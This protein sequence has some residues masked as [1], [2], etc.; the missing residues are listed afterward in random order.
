VTHWG[1]TKRGISKA[2][3]FIAA[4]G[5]FSLN[6]LVASATSI[7][8]TVTTATI[9]SSGNASV[10]SSETGT[11]YLVNE[12]L[13]ITNVASITGAADDLWNSVSISTANTNTNLAATGLRS[14]TYKVY[15][16]DAAGNLSAASTNTISIKPA[17]PAAPDLDAGSDLG[18]SPTDNNT[19]DD[20]PTFNVSSLES[21]TVV[22]LTATPSVGNPVTCSFTATGTSGTCTFDS[23]PNGTYSIRAVQSGGGVNSDASTA[24]GSVVINKQSSI[25]ANPDLD[26][27]SDFGLSKTDNITNDDTPK[28]NVSGTFFGTARVTASRAGATNVTCTISSNTCTLGSL[29][30]GVWSIAV[31]DSDS[32]G[33]SSTSAESLT[34]TIDTVRPVHSFV[35][36]RVSGGRMVVVLQSTEPGT[37]FLYWGGDPYFLRASTDTLADIRADTRDDWWNEALIASA[38]TPVEMSTVSLSRTG[39]YYTQSVMDIAGNLSVRGSPL[40]APGELSAPSATSTSAPTGT[41]TFGQILTNA[42]TYSGV[43][44]PSRTFQWKRCTSSSDT[45]TCTNISGAT[46]STYT[47]SI[48][49]VGKFLR[50]EVTASNGVGSNSTNLSSATSAILAAPYAVTDVNASSTV[51]GIQKYASV[52]LSW[53]FGADNG[54]TTANHQWSIDGTNWNNFAEGS[55][56]GT[57]GTISQSSQL[58]FGTPY[59]FRIR[60]VNSSSTSSATA[61]AAT[62]ISLLPGACNPTIS[63]DGKTYIFTTVGVCEWVIPDQIKANAATFDIRG[64]QGGGSVSLKGTNLAGGRRGGGLG[65]RIRGTINLAALNSLFVFVGSKGGE[66]TVKAKPNGVNSGGFNGGGSGNGSAYDAYGGGG[67][68]T[69]VRTTSSPAVSGNDS[70]ILVAGGGGGAAIT[71]NGGNVGLGGG[72]GSDQA[73]SYLAVGTAGQSGTYA[74]DWSGGAGGVTSSCTTSLYGVGESSTRTP[75][76]A[77]GGGGGYCGGSVGFGAREWPAPAGG[78]SSFAS[79]TYVTSA[80]AHTGGAQ[81]FNGA[82]I[83]SASG[84]NAAQVPPLDTTNCG[85]QDPNPVLSGT[86]LNG[87][88]DLAWTYSNRATTG[89]VIEYSTSSNFSPL[90]TIS[91]LDPSQ[92]TTTVNGLTNGTLYYFRMRTTNEV[93]QTLSEV[94]QLTPRLPS[95][96][97]TPTVTSPTSNTTPTVSLTSLTPG[98]TV[99]VI[100]T[101]G[102][103]TST[104][105]F[106]ATAATGTCQL[107]PALSEGTWSVRAKQSDNGVESSLSTARSLQI[108]TSAPTASV[109]TATISVS[110]NASVQSTDAGTAY[111][112]N[113]TL[114]ITNVASITGAADDLW[115]S[116]SISTANTNTNLAATGLRSGTYKVYTVDAAGNLSAASTNTISIKPAAPAAP[117]LDAGSDLGSSPTDNNTADDTP[118]FNVSSLE[119]GTVVTLT[120]TPSV[121]NPVTCS[122]T[123][124][125]TSG[126]CTFDSMPNGTYSIRAVQSGGGVNSDASTALGSVVINKRSFSTQ[127]IPDLAAAS[128]LGVSNSDD[129]TNDATP[130]FNVSGTVVGALRVTA[131]RTG[132][133]SVSC[134]IS[135]GACTLA[136]LSDGTWNITVTETDTAGNLSSASAPLS[137]SIDTVAPQRPMIATQDV[138]NNMTIPVQSSDIGTAYLVSADNSSVA[139]RAI[140]DREKYLKDFSSS[141]RTFVPILSANT[142]TNIST[143]GLTENYG[144]YL[145]VADAA[146]NVSQASANAV[147]VKASASPTNSS[148]SAPSGTTNFGQTLTNA[149]TYTGVPTPARSIQW[150]RCTSSSDTSTCSNIVGATSDTYTATSEDIGRFLR[151]NV[152]ASNG[153][154]SSVTNSSS[155]T[156]AITALTPGTPTSVTASVTGATTATVS[157]TAPTFTGGIAISSYSVSSSPTGANCSMGSNATTYNCTGLNA[158]TDYTFTVRANNSIGAGNASVAS[159]AQRTEAVDGPLTATVSNANRSLAAGLAVTPFRPI[160][161]SGGA[162][163]RTYSI[164]PTL[165]TGL[166]Y[167]TSTGAITGTPIGVSSA[168]TYTVSVNTSSSTSSANFTLGV[169]AALSATAGTIPT[170][171]YKDVAVTPFTPIFFSGGLAPVSF[172]ISPTLPAGLTFETST[173]TVRGTATGTTALTSYTVTATDANNESETRTFSLTV[174]D[175]PTAPG[176]PVIG[177]ANSTGQTSARVTFSAPSSNGGAVIESYTVTAYLAD[178]SLARITAI[179]TS[180]PITV[181]GL[182]P[183]TTYTFTVSATNSAGTSPASTSSGSITTSPSVQNN[184]G[185]GSGNSNS[186]PSQNQNQNQPV[187]PQPTPT[188]RPTASPSPTATPRPTA[189][190]SPTATPRPTASPSPTATRR[191]TPTVSPTVRPTPTVSPTA[192]PTPTVSP[193]IRPTPTPARKVNNPS[194]ERE[195]QRAL[196]TLITVEPQNLPKP[197]VLKP[198]GTPSAMKSE[199]DLA[200]TVSHAVAPGSDS[201]NV[202]IAKPNSSTEVKSYSIAITDLQTGEIRTQSISAAD[203]LNQASVNGIEPGKEYAI[204]VVATTTNNRTE[205]VSRSQLVV[206][207]SPAEKPKPITSQKNNAGTGTFSK[208]QLQPKAGQSKGKNVKITFEGLLPG[209]K[210]RITVIE[211]TK[212]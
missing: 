190:P 126:T 40:I 65:A 141:Y 143:T 52:V 3:L 16:V 135:S 157:F 120:A 50:T 207:A 74:G 49:D 29:S 72:G 81:C 139:S 12:T 198:S 176:A 155:V 171:I 106:V 128:D 150:Q 193:T 100:A 55:V 206:A 39:G 122:F 17:A 107:S 184:N 53:S 102:S 149:V 158:N 54:A 80:P 77:A 164:S 210:L 78:G 117:D 63:E 165:P 156:G 57:S 19:A 161:A 197:V 127:A 112:V 147:T 188:P 182:N 144:Y 22:T 4:I 71:G 181:T 34:I 75:Y 90:T 194:A 96:P 169:H 142:A 146:G 64:A 31:S 180:S 99:T 82:F 212:K 98:L 133:P 185:N 47:L 134:A 196:E 110:G 92:L 36:Y 87:R 88:V 83:I 104:C 30:D 1:A 200:S 14:G 84:F 89:S 118:T 2:V 95:S 7:T 160:T 183:G 9:F 48:D 42:I 178:G 51:S 132:F 137:I 140:P 199:S 61:V 167:N 68:A 97:G 43:P 33:N 114:T 25:P 67:G 70:R 56:T 26:A 18:S 145:F 195:A 58:N 168:E 38:N 129:I 121:G 148:T 103:D 111:L 211:S 136:E 5:L 119:S 69:D 66:N 93:G 20:T 152:T 159:V 11:A 76:G 37:S 59:T 10:Q 91:N 60:A 163:P 205:L 191:P 21:G 46:S 24:L 201:V 45:S 86:N 41:K 131:T 189:S 208:I 173:G 209:Q 204:A 32:S 151:T 174:L 123:A 138:T 44:S 202:T 179:G 116:V 8:A 109:T 105:T 108:D 154:G 79:S 101:S 113:E 203:V 62:P 27:T 166:T 153:V 187:T 15:T 6:S 192:R 130:T 23:M 85:G 124:T 115:N 162:G 35:E 28:I 13:T 175:T 172:A 186:Q 125:G 94:V 73:S 170:G 177:V